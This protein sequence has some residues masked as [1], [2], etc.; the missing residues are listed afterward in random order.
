MIEKYIKGFET[1]DKLLM[2]IP[3]FGW[4]FIAYGLVFPIENIYIK[5]MWYIDIFLSVPVHLLQLII[6]VPV[7]IKSGYTRFQSIYLTIAF[8]ATWWKPV[9]QMLN[10]LKPDELKSGEQ[11]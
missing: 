3:V 7:G 6:A 9:R 1:R 4:L 5:W 10:D 8:G 11:K 2:L